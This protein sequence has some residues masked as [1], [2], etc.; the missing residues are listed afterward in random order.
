MTI[1]R[2]HHTVEDVGD[3]LGTAGRRSAAQL[4]T[5]VVHD[6]N[7]PIGTITLELYTLG[8][9]LDDLAAD[10]SPE[11]FA[12]EGEALTDLRQNLGAALEHVNR[13]VH[14]L[15]D[16]AQTWTADAG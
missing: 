2:L 4:L 9:V 13:I 5:Q 16:T 10:P 12:R 14:T 15:R 11:A 3:A 1:D 6:L 8:A 7:N